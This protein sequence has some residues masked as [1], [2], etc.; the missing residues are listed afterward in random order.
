MLLLHLPLDKPGQFGLRSLQELRSSNCKFDHTQR[1][2]EHINHQLAYPTGLMN[3]LKFNSLA[4]F[5]CSSSIR[6]FSLYFSDQNL[7]YSGLVRS[8]RTS[9]N[10]GKRES[11]LPIVC[12]FNLQVGG[13]FLRRSR[14]RGR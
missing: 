6:G 7:H 4:L 2:F 8:L 3:S 9:A 13:S 14:V 10:A 5:V 11:V 12:L 1:F